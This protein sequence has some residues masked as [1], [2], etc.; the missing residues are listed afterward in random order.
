[1]KNHSWV[2]PKQKQ[3][4]KLKVRSKKVAPE[5]SGYGE[6]GFGG[7]SI[8][9]PKIKFKAPKVTI[10]KVVPKITIDTKKPLKTITNAGGDAW[11]IVNPLNIYKKAAEST[12]F[13]NDIYSG[14]DKILGGTISSVTNVSNLPTKLLKGQKISQADIMEAVMV[15]AK[16]GAIVAS[17]GSAAAL[18]SVGA[19]ALKGGPLGKT[20]FG[21]N[22]L[23]LVEIA[24]VAAAIHSAAASQVATQAA[25]QG[26]AQTSSLTAGQ[27]AQKAVENHVGNVVKTEIEKE[28]EKKTGIPVTVAT[29][30]YNVATGD[31]KL[32]TL[33]KDIAKHVA[34]EQLK[35]AGLGSTVTQAI[36]SNN[37][38]QLG[39][40]IKDAPNLLMSKAQRELQ[41]QKLK[42]E[43]YLT[44]DGL[45]KIAKEKA[46]RAIASATNLENIKKKLEAEKDKLI[47]AQL[48]KQMNKLLGEHSK[49]QKEAIDA[50][51]DAE[52]ESAVASVE[53][54]AAEEGRYVAPSKLPV[55]AG[56]GVLTIGGFF[57]MRNF[58]DE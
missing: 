30:I 41:A 7:F 48:Q 32:A 58:L 43:K 39:V 40:M 46:D 35:K 17:G 56:L 11:R 16:V 38:A 53:I 1:M 24:G 15:A 29:K 23:T 55:I 14:A 45:R 27:A 36:L 8:K 31:A 50:T 25:E 54:A 28:F 51:R 2:N 9:A 37:A 52:Y 22:F 26:A 42:A 34:E 20:S 5:F 47:Q 19:G 49:I 12:P 44:I 10:K 13:L 18:V 33:P 6:E 4:K 21:R 3:P 57:L